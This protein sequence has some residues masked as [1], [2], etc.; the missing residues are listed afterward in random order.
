M[1]IVASPQGV[2]R[3]H[4]TPVNCNSLQ[5]QII[6]PLFTLLKT[7]FLCGVPVATHHLERESRRGEGRKDAKW[8]ELGSFDPWP[9]A[10][11]L[12]AAMTQFK[13]RL[14]KQGASLNKTNP[15]PWPE[16]VRGLGPQQVN[17][18]SET[19][20]TDLKDAGKHGKE[21]ILSFSPF[22]FPNFLAEGDFRKKKQHK[23]CNEGRGFLFISSI[24]G[25]TDLLFLD[26]VFFFK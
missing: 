13:A 8:S 15:K 17:H 23:L 5:A 26:C 11:P 6:K 4:S 25:N 14:K 12:W 18:S 1:L 22:D 3:A 7:A 24:N 16:P 10:S 21:I 9:G 19:T 20:L 2:G